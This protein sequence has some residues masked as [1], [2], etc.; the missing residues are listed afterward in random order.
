MEMTIAKIWLSSPVMISSDWKV[1]CEH[2]WDLNETRASSQNF[3]VMF[4]TIAFSLPCARQKDKLGVTASSFAPATVV[5]A[6][7][8]AGADAAEVVEEKTELDVVI[9]DVPSNARIAAIN[10]V[11]GLT[12]LALKEVKELTEGLS[13]KFKEEVSRD[14]AE[15]AKKRLEEA[16][17]KVSIV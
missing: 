1:T 10:A 11:R 14:G 12:S 7:G 9:D 13:K 4:R 5:A 15:D 6:P 17:A 3:N 16:R 8:G 2:F